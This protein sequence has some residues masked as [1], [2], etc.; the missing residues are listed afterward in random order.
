MFVFLLILHGVSAVLLLGAVTHQALAAWWPVA[1]RDGHWWNSLRAVH[2]ER[3]TGAVAALYVVTFLLGAIIYAP[4]AGWARPQ[5]LDAHAPL[6]IGF[7]QIKEHA[8]ALALAML[9]AYIVAWREP[10]ARG[11]RLAFTTWLTATTW[12]NLVVG[13]VVNNLRGL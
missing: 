3:Y 11:P 6:A 12:W 8:A 1:R 7:F 13:H 9:P 2:P 4:F 5:M 10:G